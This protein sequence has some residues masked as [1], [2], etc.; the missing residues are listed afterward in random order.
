MCG[1]CRWDMGGPLPV[2]NSL[3][4]HVLFGVLT[5]HLSGPSEPSL[6]PEASAFTDAKGLSA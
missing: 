6:G 2:H 4:V 5:A 3:H 1:P